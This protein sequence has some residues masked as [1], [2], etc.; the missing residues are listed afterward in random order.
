MVK[1]I[2]S[3]QDVSKTEAVAAI[4]NSVAG[5]H[6]ELRGKSKAPTFLL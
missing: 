6:K 1:K 3:I 2:V 4:I 5:V